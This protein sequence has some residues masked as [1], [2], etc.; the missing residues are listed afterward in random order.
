MIMP[1][2]L[3]SLSYDCCFHAFVSDKVL[4]RIRKH[5]GFTREANVE[6][7]ELPVFLSLF[8]EYPWVFECVAQP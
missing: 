3:V 6:F 7:C 8:F 2:Q 4:L 1:A 5:N